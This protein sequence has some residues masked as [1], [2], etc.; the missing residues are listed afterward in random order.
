[1]M[2]RPEFTFLESFLSSS[3]MPDTTQ[4]TPYT[5]SLLSLCN[6]HI[7][8]K[9]R[10]TAPV[11]TYLPKLQSNISRPEMHLEHSFYPWNLQLE[12]SFRRSRQIWREKIW[13]GYGFRP[14]NENC[15]TMETR[16]HHWD[17]PMVGFW[18]Y[19]TVESVQ[20]K[21]T[22]KCTCTWE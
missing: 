2:N 10:Q 7:I 19:T 21:L 11:P 3:M 6:L 1:M 12:P 18:W 16:F 8:F 15:L 22:N 5:S 4:N 13:H 9:L 14:T 20:K 17:D